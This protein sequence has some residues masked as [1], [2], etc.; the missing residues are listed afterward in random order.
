MK[1]MKGTFMV[2][3]GG[4]IGNSAPKKECPGCT[5]NVYGENF[6]TNEEPPLLPAG[7]ETKPD[8]EKTEFSK[9]RSE[10]EAAGGLLPSLND[11]ILK[12]NYS[13]DKDFLPYNTK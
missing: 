12:R 6:E 3:R 8:P 10:V 11:E 1:Q 5:Q 7:V 9:L 13:D 2:M 4:Y